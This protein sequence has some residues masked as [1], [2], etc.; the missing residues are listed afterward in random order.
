MTRLKLWLMVFVM[1]AASCNLGLCFEGIN[2]KQPISTGEVIYDDSELLESRGIVWLDSVTYT[3]LGIENNSL[4]IEVKKK[5]TLISEEEDISQ[6]NLPL[7]DKKQTLLKANPPS[8]TLRHPEL[9]ITVVDEF[10]RIKV[11]EYK[12]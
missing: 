11:E 2:P 7:N 6:L 5:A 12:E 4:K 10:F 1:V 9:L 3:Y 8:S